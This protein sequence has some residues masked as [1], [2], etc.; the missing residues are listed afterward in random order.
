MRLRYL[1]KKELLEMIRQK[2]LL[3]LIFVAPV[4]QIII[5]GYVVSTDIRHV[6]VGI[7]NLA[8]GHK[9][10][11]IILRIDHT[12]LFNVRWKTNLPEDYLAHLKKGTVKAIIVFRDALD[13]KRTEALDL[14]IEGLRKKAKVEIND[15]L[16]KAI[17][18]N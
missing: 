1:I 5:L 14:W 9:A 18:L 2:E 7:V 13:K 11:Q 4:L 16:L 3:F 17:K 8:A 15:K 10:Q 12:P 6:P